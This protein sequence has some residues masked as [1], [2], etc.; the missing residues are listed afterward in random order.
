MR[1]GKRMGKKGGEK[2][3]GM[4]GK[5]SREKRE[6]ENPKQREWKESWKGKVG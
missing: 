2:E 5:E 1:V 6:G 3:R 4:K